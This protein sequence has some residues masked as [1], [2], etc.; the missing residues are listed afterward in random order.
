MTRLWRQYREVVVDSIDLSSFDLEIEVTKPDDDPMEFDVTAYNLTDST[1]ERI[2]TESQ[3]RITLGWEE[4]DRDTICFG[5]INKKN[6]IRDGTD[7][8]YVMKGVD[9]TDE[10]LTTAFSARWRDSTPTEIVEDIA[11]QLG[12]AADVD[13]VPDP[14]SGIWSIT[15]DRKVKEWLD[16]LLDYAAE[17]TGVQWEWFAEAGTLYFLRTNSTRGEAPMLSYNGLLLS[18]DQKDDEEDSETETLEFEA[19]L[20]PRIK[21]GAAVVVDTDRFDGVYKVQNYEY[22]SNTIGGEHR[23]T[24]DVESTDEIKAFDPT[25]QG[26]AGDSFRPI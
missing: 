8:Q 12:L 26:P 9:V 11:G 22:V 10:Q 13:D 25:P 14:I 2:S 15:T 1:W 18:I 16:E 21:K 7:T 4:S 17:F 19:M 24:G 23:V 3:I 5:D 6:R 20:D